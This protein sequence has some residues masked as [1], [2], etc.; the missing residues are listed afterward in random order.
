MGDVQNIAG[1]SI[2]V[3]VCYILSQLF[4]YRYNQKYP[5]TNCDEYTHS[6]RSILSLRY[7]VWGNTIHR[8]LRGLMFLYWLGLGWITKWIRDA[9]RPRFYMFTVWNIILMSVYFLLASISSW[10]YW[11]DPNN[12]DKSFPAWWPKAAR[13]WTA[14]VV[15]VL[16]SVIGGC[17]LFVTITAWQGHGGFWAIQQHLTNICLFLIEGFQVSICNVIMCVSRVSYRECVQR[18]LALLFLHPSS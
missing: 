7:A 2:M 4:I 9:P 6:G 12:Q 13:N 14:H 11:I 17:A 10:Q 5:V 8:V 1:V 18:Y 15:R 16:H 3:T